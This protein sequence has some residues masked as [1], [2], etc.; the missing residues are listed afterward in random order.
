MNKDYLNILK[1]QMGDRKGMT[2][3][4]ARQ[5]LFKGKLLTELFIGMADIAKL[6]PSERDKAM[7]RLAIIA[8]YDATNLYE[9]MAEF[10]DNP[11]IKKVMLDIANEEKAHIGEF[12]FLLEHFDKEHEKYENEGEEEAKELTGMPD[13][14][15]EED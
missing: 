10:T 8:E 9:K 14:P 2:L 5:K 13:H 3:S 6:S 15:N 1:E 7:L 11:N 12:E 4:E